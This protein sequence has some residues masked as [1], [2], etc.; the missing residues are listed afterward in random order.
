MESKIVIFIQFRFK[1]HVQ[2]YTLLLWHV[3][4]EA[5]VWCFKWKKVKPAARKILGTIIFQCSD[6]EWN[7]KEDQPIKNW[8]ENL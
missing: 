6:S 1:L 2:K 3:Q 7:L 4:I 8:D 5:W